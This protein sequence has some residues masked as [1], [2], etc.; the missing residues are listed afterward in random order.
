M[1]AD[2]ILFRDLA[3]V[4]VAAVLGGSLAWLTRQ[5]LILGYVIGGLLI[6][7]LTPGPAVSDIHTFELFAEIGVVLLMF[8]LGIEFSLKDLMGVKWIALIGGPIGIVLSTAVGLAVGS[9][10]GWSPVAGAVIGMVV[11]PASTMVLA[12]LLLDRGEL[13]SRHGRIMIGIT[14]VEDLAA[15]VLIIL[16]PALGTMQGDRVLAVAKALLTAAAILVPFFY[17]AS[18]ILPQVLARVARTRNE[19]LLLLVTLALGLGA[20]AVTQAAGLSLALGAFLAGLLINQSDYAHEMLARLLSLRDAFV[21]LFFVTVGVL[22]DLRVVVDN[23]GLLGVLVGLVVIGQW[24]IWTVV[25]LLFRQSLS[26]ALLVGVGLAQ[27]GEFSFILVQVAREAGHVGAD[28]YSATLAASLV[29]ILINAALVRLVPR[30]I[31]P[32]RLTKGSMPALGLPSGPA[33]EGH[34]VVCGFGRVGSAIGE[35]LETFNIPYMVIETDPDIVKSLRARNVPAVFGDA[36]QRVILAA[37]QADQAA[38]VILAI[39]ENDRA[40]Q[41]VRRIRSFNPTVQILAR[42]HDLAWRARLMEAGAA[43]VIQPEE[44]AA[45]TLIRHALERLSLPRERVLA[46]LNRFRGAMERAKAEAEEV[47]AGLPQLR[48]V[49]LRGGNLVGQSLGE[50]RVRERFGV[51]VVAVTRVTGEQVADPTAETVLRRGDRLRL[52]GLP[53]QIDTLLSGS[54]VLI[55]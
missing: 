3:Y 29:T 13:H 25:S 1:S 20:A 36:A 54:E 50:A 10:L 49:S 40:R 7:P 27:I 24:A 12:R 48:E 2:P 51:T 32:A 23:I 37:A 26:T 46:Y 30:W 52:F 34:V 8:S 44:E 6:S 14:L 39:P 4:F 22:I 35:A 55:E 41:A 53:R 5:P 9:L 28:V 43:E 47:G 42:V 45:S 21:A 16:I 33:L 19:E 18:R 15:V 31:G 17:L 11:S 38:L